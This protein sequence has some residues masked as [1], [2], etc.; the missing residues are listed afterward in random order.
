MFGFLHCF[1]G[2]LGR[3]TGYGPADQSAGVLEIVSR[4]LFL[5]SS[6]SVQPC[7]RLVDGCHVQGPPQEAYVGHTWTGVGS[8]CVV[9]VGFSPAG[10]TLIRITATLGYE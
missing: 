3:E 4:A 5:K 2:W 7:R 8:I 6:D 10:C 9:L 1:I